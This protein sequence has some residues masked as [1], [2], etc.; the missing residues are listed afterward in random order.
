VRSVAKAHAVTTKRAA[1]RMGPIVPNELSA[2]AR[3]AT[4]PMCRPPVYRTS[5]TA[6]VPSPVPTKVAWVQQSSRRARAGSLWD[7]LLTR[8]VC[9]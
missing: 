6:G 5:R 9:Q 3:Q 8:Q 7:L 2:T 1:A 4:T